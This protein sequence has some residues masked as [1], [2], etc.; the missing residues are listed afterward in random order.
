MEWIMG[1]WERERDKE[2]SSSWNGKDDKYDIHL[3][4]K[5]SFNH[6]KHL[7]DRASDTDLHMAAQFDTL[8]QNKILDIFFE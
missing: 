2:H 1:E 5:Y 4:D 3:K 6:S 7:G 8:K